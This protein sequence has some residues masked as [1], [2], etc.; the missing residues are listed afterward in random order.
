MFHDFHLKKYMRSIDYNIYLVIFVFIGL[1]CLF[2]THALT[3][4]LPY[5]IGSAMFLYG[6][7]HIVIGRVERVHYDMGRCLLF[8]ILGG[9]I[10]FQGNNALGV[11]GTIWALI[12]LNNI[13]EDFNDMYPHDFSFIECVEIIISTV[14][15]LMLLWEPYHHFIFHVRVLGVEMI[16]NALLR[17]KHNKRSG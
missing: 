12:S 11:M 8:M 13:A 15:A 10:L 1:L 3:N 5:I 17:Y 2:F 14:L 9:M 7:F 6:P 4:A 16:I